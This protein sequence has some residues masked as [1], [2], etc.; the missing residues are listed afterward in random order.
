MNYMKCGKTFIQRLHP[1]VSQYP[2]ITSDTTELKIQNIQNTSKLRDF[3]QH[4]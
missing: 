4:H 3:A 1:L 2:E